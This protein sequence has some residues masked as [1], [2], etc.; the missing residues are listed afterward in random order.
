MKHNVR[1]ICSEK[2]VY[3]IYLTSVF[4][5][6]R[7]H[8]SFIVLHFLYQFSYFKHIKNKRRNNKRLILIIFYKYYDRIITLI[9]IIVIAYK[10]N[11]VYK[12]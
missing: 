9:V 5:G 8:I 7:I 2:D 10:A 1:Q 11:P 3:T 6:D 12:C 4:L